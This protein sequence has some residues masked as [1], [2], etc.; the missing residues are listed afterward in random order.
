MVT[1]QR[2]VVQLRSQF[3]RHFNKLLSIESVEKLA[4]SSSRPADFACLHLGRTL[5]GWTAPP[6]TPRLTLS[7]SL[8]ATTPKLHSDRLVWDKF[9]CPCARRITATTSSSGF[10]QSE[11]DDL[12]RSSMIRSVAT[13]IP[14]PLVV[15]GL[16]ALHTL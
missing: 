11:N 12:T 10:D 6:P 3:T 9:R 8:S 15:D 1:H 4:Q 14:A 13:S 5:Q 2:S 7:V 16:P